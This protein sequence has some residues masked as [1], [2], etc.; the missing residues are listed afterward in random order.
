MCRAEY[1][2]ELDKC[3][4]CGSHVSTTGYGDRSS[5][6]YVAPKKETST[7]TNSSIIG[8]VAEVLADVVIACASTAGNVV[9]NTFDFLSDIDFGGGGAGDFFD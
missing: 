2:F 4:R 8:D 3:P 7:D 5:T 1:D 9:G 6:N